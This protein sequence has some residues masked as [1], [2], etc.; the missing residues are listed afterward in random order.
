MKQDNGDMKCG[1]LGYSA[2]LLPF[3]P[4][5]RPCPCTGRVPTGTQLTWEEGAQGFVTYYSHTITR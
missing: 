5:R 4:S 3:P 2:P 1:Y